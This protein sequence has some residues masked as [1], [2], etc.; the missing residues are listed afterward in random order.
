MCFCRLEAKSKSRTLGRKER[1]CIVKVAILLLECLL[2][3]S[4][5]SDFDF[6][7]ERFYGSKGRWTIPHFEVSLR[8]P[9]APGDAS[10][11]I[12]F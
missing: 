11:F 12:P 8:F 2:W 7:P 3:S 9:G 5:S 4:D 10:L 6:R 1:G